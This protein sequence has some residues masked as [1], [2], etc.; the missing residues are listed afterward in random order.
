MKNIFQQ[1]ARL[2]HKPESEN[3]F[4][5]NRG[6]NTNSHQEI[7]LFQIKTHQYL[8]ESVKKLKKLN[9]Y[10][11]K[12]LSLAILISLS[13]IWSQGYHSLVKAADFMTPLSTRGSQIVNAQGNPVVFKGVN[14]FGIETDVHVPHG[15][16][17]RDYKEMITQMK[18]LGYNT[19]RL[20]FSLNALRSNNI[21]AINYYI[22]SNSELQGKTPQQVMDI[23][24]QE[25]GRQGFYVILDSQRNN[26]YQ[27]PE[28]WYGDGFSED[29]WI[30][31][32]KMLAQRYKNYPNVVG[33]DL[34]NEPH[35]RASW[36]TG[37]YS[38][39]WR[40]A[41]ERAGNAILSVNPNW[42][43]IVEGVERNVKDAT[44]PYSW[45]G[46][47]LEGVKKY[48]VRLNVKNKLVYSIHEYGQ[49]VADQTWFH[50]SNFPNNLEA[51]W[52][53]VF[54]YINT[55]NIAPVYI[56]EFGGRKADYS[57]KEGMWQNK[58]AQ[59]VKNKNLSFTYWSWNPNSSDTGGLLLDDWTNIDS[60][61]HEMMKPLLNGSVVVN[62]PKPPNPIL[63]SNLQANSTISNNWNSG[64]CA[65]IKVTNN[66]K[67]AINN[68]KM[69]FKINQASIFNSWNANF[70]SQG[71]TYQATPI[72][73]WAKKI[74]P[75]QSVE[76]GYCANKQG[77]NYQP[78]D[79]SVQPL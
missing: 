78:S 44:I 19:V 33:A 72:Q 7:N 25:L 58:F 52:E 48:P 35:G 45:W 4:I 31:T 55:E 41:A 51:R 30:N 26:D 20:P 6:I 10:K 60:A 9:K 27:I 1:I 76:V 42:L 39:D 8:D 47:H 50:E 68:W 77:G 21:D 15:L 54:N 24:I 5:S 34:K 59:F 32:W 64:F 67:T 13:I 65:S 63:T 12:P 61:K 70:V 53:K 79:F 46:G 56:G 3:L 17:V 11:V 23:V 2:F 38:T 40:L 49:G 74:N 37:D 18:N 71:S 16:W 73:D 75:G 62:P 69:T 57:S 14:W 22:G 28:L 29:D 66:G 36:G 43:I